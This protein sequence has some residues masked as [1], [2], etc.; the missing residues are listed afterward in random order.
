MQK[1]L[2]FQNFTFVFWRDLMIKIGK[3]MPLILI[4]NFLDRN[5][6]VFDTFLTAKTMK[7]PKINF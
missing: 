1:I 3:V 2:L 7:K 4:E 5:Q 6:K